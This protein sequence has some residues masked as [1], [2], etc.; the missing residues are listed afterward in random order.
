MSPLVVGR[1]PFSILGYADALEFFQD[2]YEVSHA[3]NPMVSYDSLA[4]ACG[5]KSRTF[6]RN[7]IKGTQTATLAQ[8][9]KLGEVFSFNATELNYLDCL[10]RFK[11]T[12]ENATAF[13]LFQDLLKFQR[14][15]GTQE[16]PFRELEVATSLLHLSLL[17]L[18]EIKAFEEDTIVLARLLRD[19]YSPTEIQTAI[20]EL[21]K[22]GYVTREAGVLKQNQSYVKKIDLKSN[23]FLR[24]FHAECLTL[25]Q[26]AL[27]EFPTEDR[28]LVGVNFAIPE[29]NF[30]RI[31]QKLNGFLENIMQTENATG[32]AEAVVQL[33]A[34]LIRMTA[35][36]H[37]APTEQ[38]LSRKTTETV[39]GEKTNNQALSANADDGF[40][41]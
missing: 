28:Y 33:N 31:V 12:S 41:K 13:A 21:E 30:Q 32:R 22:Y 39:S 17:S 27:F 37:V 23:H 14:E 40:E 5:F 1:L 15:Q 36:N 2:A 18:M 19:R 7:L 29:K 8:W 4:Q 6:C 9:K 25:S 24:M 35:S 11:S 38:M 10:V 34:Q 20:T 16:N 26:K 3:Q